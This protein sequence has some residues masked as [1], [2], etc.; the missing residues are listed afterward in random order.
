MARGC[1]L[2]ALPG[3]SPAQLPGVTL[4]PLP[5]GVLAEDRPR[6]GRARRA[7]EGA[8]LAIAAS[9]ASPEVAGAVASKVAALWDR[10]GELGVAMG[11]GRAFLVEFAPD[12]LARTRAELEIRALEVDFLQ[13]K[14][15]D[16]ER[17]AF[18]ALAHRAGE[19]RGD[20]SVLEARLEA[21][22]A[23]LEALRGATERIAVGGASVLDALAAEEA[24][25]Q[26]AVEA[27]ARTIAELGR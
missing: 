11:R 3:R 1:F 27:F 21:V 6:L 24:E 14:A 12:R 19:V 13:Q 10:A 20:V 2:F 23:T 4:R 8:I 9:P 16:Q 7:A 26:R 25:A 17:E 18:D 15:I 22:I 5:A